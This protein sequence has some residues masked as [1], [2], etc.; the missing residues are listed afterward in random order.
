MFGKKPEATPY[1]LEKL[2]G[3]YK[4]NI[5]ELTAIRAIVAAGGKVS[6]HRIRDLKKAAKA[7][8]RFE[9]SIGVK[10]GQVIADE[11]RDDLKALQVPVAYESPTPNTCERCGQACRPG[12][13][14]CLFCEGEQIAATG[15]DANE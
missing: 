6:R 11:Q 9:K 12:E 13:N 2:T 1:Q 10:T 8:E 14:V 7:V 3:M 5:A 15:T 4:A